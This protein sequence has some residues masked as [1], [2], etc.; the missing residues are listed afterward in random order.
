ME[1]DG[2]E[3]RAYAW[4]EAGERFTLLDWSGGVGALQVRIR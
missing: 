3:S 1:G 2:S 4:V